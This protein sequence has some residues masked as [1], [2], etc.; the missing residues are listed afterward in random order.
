M[1]VQFLADASG[2]L[3]KAESVKEFRTLLFAAV[4]NAYTAGLSRTHGEA[5]S[6]KPLSA[7]ARG[8]DTASETLERCTK[9]VASLLDAIEKWGPRT[10]GFSWRT[11]T[12]R[13]SYEARILIE[14]AREFGRAHRSVCD[15]VA[16]SNVVPLP[17][18]KTALPVAIAANFSLRNKLEAKL[19]A[20]KQAQPASA[21]D[22]LAHLP[23]EIRAAVQAVGADSPAGKAILT[24]YQAPARRSKTQ[25]SKPC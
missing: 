21:T 20:A 3:E 16:V 18:S 5:R 11:T 13:A 14:A 2:N 7:L 22:P 25:P 8:F 19:A 17:Q 15:A 1:N 23:P 24:Q 10:E 12:S 9:G 6:D 4:G